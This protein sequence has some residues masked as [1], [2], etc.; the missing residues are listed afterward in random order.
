MN[1]FSSSQVLLDAAIKTKIKHAFLTGN[2]STY[3]V[4]KLWLEQA[5]DIL[6]YTFHAKRLAANEFIDLSDDEGI[7]EC[8]K[9]IVS[10]LC[11]YIEKQI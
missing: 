8:V 9:A 3:R 6:I 11:C 5:T 10:H 1:S 7:D 2:D 4:D